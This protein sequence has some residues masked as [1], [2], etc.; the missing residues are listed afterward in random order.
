MPLKEEL[1]FFKGSYKGS[2][3]GFPLRVIIGFHNRVPLRVLLRVP[4]RFHL[5]VP[6]EGIPL[7]VPV[8]EG[9]GSVTVPRGGFFEGYYKV[10][11]GFG[12]QEL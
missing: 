1:G 5:R 11:K 7:R 10:L 8:G 9:G 2:R 6:I 3:T 12:V 4:L